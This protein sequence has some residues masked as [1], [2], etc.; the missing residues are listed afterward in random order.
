MST[1]KLFNGQIELLSVDDIAKALGVHNVTILRYIRSGKLKARKIGR[2][3][4]I[5]KENFEKFVNLE[6]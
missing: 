2:G 6:E 5:S 4:Y 3:Y 1:K